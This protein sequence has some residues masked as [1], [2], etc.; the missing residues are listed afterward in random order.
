MARSWYRGRRGDGWERF[1]SAVL[2][3]A[4]VGLVFA[5]SA[6]AADNPALP[7]VGFGHQ[8]PSYNLSDA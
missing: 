2:S 4:L 3:M 1:W 5:V 8:R 6:S 7:P